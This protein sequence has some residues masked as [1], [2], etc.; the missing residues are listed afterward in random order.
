MNA[1]LKVMG[2]IGA[3]ILAFFGVILVI[4]MT[5]GGGLLI[6]G[7]LSF[8]AFLVIV[9]AVAAAIYYS[10]APPEKDNKLK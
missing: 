8:I 1:L 10:I 4:V 7:V 3:F 2:G 9:W 5:V 6:A